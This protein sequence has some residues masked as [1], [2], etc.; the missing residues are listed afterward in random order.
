MMQMK[1][2]LIL[3]LLMTVACPWTASGQTN[4]IETLVAQA[5]SGNP[6]LQAA[7]SEV[8][9]ARGERR[10]T[11]QWK[12]PEVTAQYGEKRVAERTTGELAGKGGAQFYSFSQTFEF[13][14]KAGLRK[15]IA[16][17]D[18]RLAGLAL[19]QL[20][21]EIAAEAR[22]L[23]IRW[24]T[25][26][27]EAVAAREVADRSETL[28]QMLGKRVPAGVQFL[29][30]QRIIEAS[31]VNNLNRAREAEEARETTR[32]ALNILRGRRP[33]NAL[34][35][36]KP[37]DPPA[38]K[39]G[40]DALWLQAS[41]TNPALRSG[42][43]KVGR[44]QRALS[45]SKLEAAPDFTISPFYSEARAVDRERILGVGISLPL[46]FWD[47]GRGR[48]DAA[49][50]GLARAE[51][52]RART[53]RTVQQRLAEELNA[54][55]LASKQLEKTPQALLSR[56]REGAE[57][58]D[59]QYRLGTV[60]IATYIEM[61]DQYL[62]ATAGLLGTIRDAHEHRLNILLLTADPALLPPAPAAGGKP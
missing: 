20:R 49:R 2:V 61:Q 32:I 16:D 23:A 25:F 15:A 17:H 41:A 26:E 40:W 55:K 38:A 45:R 42:D 53:A 43:E 54:W 39:A 59:R 5:L 62:E 11:G 36:A 12:N 13:P 27:E 29:L 21:L 51:A 8:A 57:L 48:T 30:D 56:F 34:E 60:E 47:S 58:A 28:A 7:E 4:S 46:P 22:L 9:V 44:A 14:G 37:P 6:D 19:E 24:L 10:A 35:V 33:D 3:L 52:E 18:V 50:A 1:P 31:L